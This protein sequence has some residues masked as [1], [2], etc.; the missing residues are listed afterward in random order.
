[1]SA[2]QDRDKQRKALK[3]HFVDIIRKG[4]RKPVSARD[5]P[6]S[7][8]QGDFRTEPQTEPPQSELPQGDPEP[9][10]H[11]VTFDE[12]GNAIWKLKSQMDS[13]ELVDATVDI[14]GCLDNAD[15]SIEDD[16]RDE[17]RADKS[18]KDPYNN[19]ES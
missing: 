7:G 1:M 9:M 3:A 16:A 10:Q 6:D 2:N 15:L 17:Q 4:R 13:D 19:S 5:L 11:K 8:S 18:G 12:K 14:L